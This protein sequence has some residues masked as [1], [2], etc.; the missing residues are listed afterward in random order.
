MR[1]R[2]IKTDAIMSNSV[3]RALASMEWV[4]RAHAF[5]PTNVSARGDLWVQPIWQIGADTRHALST[6]HRVS[7]L[8]PGSC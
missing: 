5:G 8:R 2:G 1:M 7:G 4:R 6:V 3:G